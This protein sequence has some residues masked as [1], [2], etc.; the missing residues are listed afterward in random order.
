MIRFYL[1]IYNGSCADD[2]GMSQSSQMR[3]TCELSAWIGESGRCQWCNKALV[4]KSG[5]R[6]FC[7]SNCAK[8]FEKNHLW[9]L[10]RRAAKRRAKYKCV[11]PGCLDDTGYIEVNHINP[12]VGQGYGQS[13]FHHEVNLEALCKPHHQIETNRQRE[14]RKEDGI[15]NKEFNEL[16]KKEE[17]VKE[18]RLELLSANPGVHETPELDDYE[19]D[20]KELLSE[21]DESDDDNLKYLVEDDFI[22]VTP[23]P[24]RLGPKRPYR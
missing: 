23:E 2:E 22:E 19:E 5:K 21:E 12:L 6:A 1:F 8:T 3:L 4:A 7:S 11:R 18:F 9:N 15:R 17:Y 20:A 13:C 16:L 24:V 14:E 10:A